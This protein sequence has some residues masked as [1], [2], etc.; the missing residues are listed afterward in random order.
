MKPAITS[1]T[2]E[3]FRALRKLTIKGLGRVNLITGRNNTGKS[4]VLEAL[5]LLASEAS[6]TV[7]FSILNAREEVSGEAGELGWWTDTNALFQLA[8]LFSG[9]PDLT[10]SLRPVS[11][12]STGSRRLLKLTLRVRG[13]SRKGDSD[14]SQKLIELDEDYF[15]HDEDLPGLI[16]EGASGKRSFSTDRLGRRSFSSHPH[17]YDFREEGQLRCVYVSPYG[18]ERT[19]NLSALW[20]NIALSS[21]EEAVVE[22]LRI[23][24]PQISAVSMVGGEGP[25]RARTAIVRSG[26][27]E[28]PVPLRSFGDGLNRL[29]GIVL[30]LVNAKDG[31]VL[32][33]EFENGMHHT[34]QLNTWRAIFRLAKSLDVQVFATSHSWDAIEAFQKA[35]TESPEDGVLVRL[36]RKDDKIIPTVFREDELAVATRDGIEVR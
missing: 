27:F 16:I 2:I 1:L 10:K 17:R 4:S 28:R 12:R 13:F 18:G 8:G 36:S 7:L 23:I 26:N 19:A 21:R 25:G 30:S 22:A 34:V 32:I 15:G 14:D 6:T 5:R 24:D 29:F 31:L 9:F 3:G 35:A 11:I 20:D 33:D